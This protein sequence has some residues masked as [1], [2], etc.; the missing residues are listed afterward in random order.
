M[1]LILID[2]NFKDIKLAMP[3]SLRASLST[4]ITVSGVTTI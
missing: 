3:E 2:M 1:Q 4:S